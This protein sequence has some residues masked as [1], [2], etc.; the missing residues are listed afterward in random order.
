MRRLFFVLLVLLLPLRGWSG[1]AMAIHMALPAPIQQ[2]SGVD[3]VGHLDLGE[4]SAHVYAM[5]SAVMSA[6]GDCASH[7]DTQETGSTDM[8]DCGT[9]SMC[10]T[11]HTV[12][13]LISMAVPDHGPVPLAAPQHV[14][15]GFS[16]AD[17]AL[18]LKPPTT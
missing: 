12:A 17:G 14:A 5:A 4:D 18:A 8:A 16:S 2:V 6:A 13:V 3:V 15:H 11:C 1:D 10:Q 9:C 7:G